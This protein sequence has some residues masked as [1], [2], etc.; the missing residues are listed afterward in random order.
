MNVNHLSLTRAAGLLAGAL[1]VVASVPLARAAASTAEADAL[2][3]FTENYIKVGG[4]APELSGSHTGFQRGTQIAKR[5]TGGIE[6][7]NYTVDLDKQTNLQ[8]N[9][10]AL[11]GAEDYLAQFKVTKDKV[12]SFE[13]GYKRVRTFY[14]GMGGFFPLN[15]AWLPL[16]QRALF[17]DRGNLFVNGT[18]ALPKAPVFTFSY[19][20]ETRSGRKDSTIWGDTDLTGIAV[21]RPTSLNTYSSNRKIIPAYIQLG[22]RQ[23]TWEAAVKHSV[24]D[25]TFRLA[26]IGNRIN[27]LDT[28]S[29]DRYPGEV[30][31]YP[32]FP[33][34][35]PSPIIVPPLL[36]ANANKGFDQQGFKEDGLTWVGK[37]ETTLSPQAK[38]YVSANYR[39]ATMDVA[40]SRLITASIMTATGVSQ[41]VGGFTPGGRS[42]YSPSGTGSLKE[43]VLTGAIGIEYTPSKE[44]ELSAALK[45]EDLKT[46]GNFNAT[47]TTNMVV[48]AT[49]VV[50]PV[51]LTAPNSNNI[52]ER[53]W[54]PEVSVRYTGIKS[55]ALFAMW[56]YRTMSQ[57][58]RTSYVGLTTGPTVMVL[59]APS[60]ANDKVKEKHSNL[61]LGGNWTPNSM[62]TLRGEFFTKDHENRFTGYG[63]TLGS[64]YIL[65]Y[66]T[67]GVRATATVRPSPVV[68]LST[69]YIA[70]RGK[71][72]EAE[73]GFLK[74]N[75]NDSRRYQLSETIDWNPNKLVYVQ[76]N[77]SVVWDSINTVYPRA[78]GNANNVLHNADNNFWNG[79]V[80]TGYVIDKE[81]DAQVQA[82]YYKANNYNPSMAF[83]TTPYGQ[84]G[85]DY[86]LTVGL[87]HKFSDR[88]VGSCKVGYFNSNNDTT[89]GFA[90]Y[91]GTV[92]YLSL[93]YRL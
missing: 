78:G 25:T 18:I 88:M 9:G 13:A 89:G 29:V 72:Q 81:T 69:R 48:Q 67:Y 19:R 45:G 8:V 31:A 53:P 40:S 7:F 65:N 84:G 50:T 5:G 3:A 38:A 87:K 82:T 42:P 74:G 47:Y 54:V 58:E 43:D 93:D 92:G 37:V 33:A 51:N 46:S 79:S 36:V 11:P 49:G 91:K 52:T 24:G 14:D 75:S 76:G 56:D 10:R 68:S 30:A 20:N 55:I 15:N 59:S 83:A 17:V 23:E 64:Y 44:L 27:N 12:G 60:G 4:N 34:N 71:A 61:K 22:E 35:P 26:V 21:Y 77:V 16:Y 63:P 41:L 73:D 39:H 62:F 86:S 2:P 28:R 66:D 32:A 85:R 6:E 70:Q 80:L 1:F 57:D 90:S